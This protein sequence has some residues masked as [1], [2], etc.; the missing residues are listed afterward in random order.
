MPRLAGHAHRTAHAAVALGLGLALV[1]GAAFASPPEWMH[2][3]HG[4]DMAHHGDHM[5]HH[6]GH[7]PGD[8][9]GVPALDDH[10][11]RSVVTAGS[12]AI[13]AVRVCDHDVHVAVIAAGQG[14][15]R[16]LGGDCDHADHTAA[17]AMAG[18]GAVGMATDGAALTAPPATAPSLGQ[19]LAI[20][21]AA[22]AAAPVGHAGSMDMGMGMAMGHHRM[23][24]A[25]GGGHA[26]PGDMHVGRGGLYGMARGDRAR[27]EGRVRGMRAV[28][29]AQDRD[30]DRDGKG[31]RKGRGGQVTAMPSTGAGMPGAPDP[32]MQA[33]LAAVASAAAG[34]AGFRRRTAGS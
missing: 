23:G 33:V 20:D 11:T 22:A 24:M 30:R 25:T 34:L 18:G 1:P 4:D 31:G 8:W 32:V 10:P 12:G 26:G 13:A 3:H 16:I 5:A 2:P 19:A 21:A 29:G 28:G 7:M 27:G 14:G 6:G 15:E 17:L 9:P